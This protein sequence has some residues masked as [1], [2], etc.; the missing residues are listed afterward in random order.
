MRIKGACTAVASSLSCAFGGG[1]I[2][3]LNHKQGERMCI[4]RAI[5]TAVAA[6]LY[7]ACT[8]RAQ[9]QVFSLDDAPPAPPPKTTLNDAMDK[10]GPTKSIQDA[11]FDFG[12]LIEGSYSYNTDGGGPDVIPTRV[13]DIDNNR[14][15]LNQAALY[16]QRAVAASK[17]KFDL[18]GRVDV[19]YGRDAR[20]I[21]G[22]GQDIYGTGGPQLKPNEQFD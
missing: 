12:G 15:I 16:A 2:G 9:T 20:F 3:N 14:V 19:M 1:C 18:G 13:F 6:S 17:D 22:N 8:L 21:H 4:R 11:G 10:W 5:A 7:F